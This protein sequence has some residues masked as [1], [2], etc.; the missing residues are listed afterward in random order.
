MSVHQADKKKYDLVEDLVRT[1]YETRDLYLVKA[2]RSLLPDISLMTAKYWIKEAKKEVRIERLEN[3]IERLEKLLNQDPDDDEESA[4]A[5]LI[6]E[7]RYHEN[8]PPSVFGERWKL[9]HTSESDSIY[10]RTVWV[11]EEILS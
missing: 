8:P 10:P 6:V 1:N 2:A 7:N 9:I 4:R 5:G 3:R 11:C